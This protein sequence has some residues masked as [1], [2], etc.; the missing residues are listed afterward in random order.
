MYISEKTEWITNMIKFIAAEKSKVISTCGTPKE[1]HT[2]R[3]K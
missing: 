1:S 3:E 2:I